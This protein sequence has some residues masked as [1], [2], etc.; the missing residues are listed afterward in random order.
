MEDSVH[1]TLAE[2]VGSLFPSHIILKQ[3]LYNLPAVSC[4]GNDRRPNL[5]ELLSARLVL[6]SNFIS[7]SFSHSLMLS[8]STTE[9]SSRSIL[10]TRIVTLVSQ[11]SFI[12]T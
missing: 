10:T 4:P 2:P 5:G 7:C 12:N 6:G 1:P 8:F 11:P 9:T 3:P